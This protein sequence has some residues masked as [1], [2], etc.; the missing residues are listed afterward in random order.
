MK[1]DFS[2][3]LLVI[4][5]V[6]P[7]LFAQRSRNLIA[8]RSFAAQGAAGELAE[9]VALGI[10]TH[11]VLAYFA[12]IL[13]VLLGLIFHC[14]AFCFFRLIDSW[15]P[16]EWC[17]TH[18]TETFLLALTYVFLSFFVSHLLGL[19]YGIWR[20]NSPFTTVLLGNRHWYTKWLERRGVRGILGE[21]PVIY[22]VLNEKLDGNGI[23]RI[24]FVELE[25]KDGLGFY[26]GQLDQFSIVKDE[27]PHKPVFLINAWFK[28]ERTEIYKRLEADGVMIDLADAA[29]L[30]IKQVAAGQQEIENP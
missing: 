4:V 16:G 28:K 8:P 5:A 9:F 21:H 27:E 11:G 12:A 18:S 6:I 29:I 10:A 22:E 13:L 30:Q 14:G 15:H 26:S 2:T 7:G 23:P 3:I 17:G 19:A 25:M 20:L 24:V 1:I